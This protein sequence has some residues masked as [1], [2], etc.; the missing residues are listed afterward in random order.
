MLKIR[1]LQ[2]ACTV[3]MLAAV[4]AFAQSNTPVTSD[5]TAAAPADHQATPDKTSMSDSKSTMSPGDK[6]GD[7]AGHANHARRTAMAHPAGTMHSSRTDTSQNST[8]DQLNDQSYQASQKG[9][10]LG[11]RG[12]DSAS[13]D[14]AKP[15]AARPNGTGSMNDMSGGSMSGSGTAGTG[16]KP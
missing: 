12:T 16:T 10:A 13:S 11:G 8:I 6:N 7:S 15:A 9:E 3:A 5:G 14:M 4:P 2:A 1:L